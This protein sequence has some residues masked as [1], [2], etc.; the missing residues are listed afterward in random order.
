MSFG[1]AH[2]STLEHSD[3]TADK[4]PN[5]HPGITHK[6]SNHINP[7]HVTIVRT[8]NHADSFSNDGTNNGSA[9]LF[10]H[11]F[12]HCDPDHGT[13]SHTF[14]N[15]QQWPYHVSERGSNTHT[16]LA[17]RS[18]H[19]CYANGFPVSHSVNR[20]NVDTNAAA[21]GIAYCCTVNS[22]DTV[23]N[24]AHN[25]RTDSIPSHHCLADD[26]RTCY[27]ASNNHITDVT[28]PNH[29]YACVL[30]PSDVRTYHGIA[31]NRI[32]HHN[33]THLVRSHYTGTNNRGADN[34]VSNDP[35]P[36]TASPTTL[37][38]TTQFPTSLAPSL[39]PT[40]A[41]SGVFPNTAALST[42]SSTSHDGA[43]VAVIVAVVVFVV[44][45]SANPIFEL[46][47]RCGGLRPRD[48]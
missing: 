18:T 41:P 23:S 33:S 34:R 21:I 8:I 4:E 12:T 40:N 32:T 38:P 11:D 28:H 2:S 3:N 48:D 6:Q 26:A 42:R 43:T 19:H 46:M 9:D 25:K 1:N 7:N 13:H 15:A 5:T 17:H 47:M 22:T 39:F 20:P 16:K 10:T 35:A 27:A 31:H 36:V 37:V 24:S 45:V 14:C 29:R 30:C 44:V